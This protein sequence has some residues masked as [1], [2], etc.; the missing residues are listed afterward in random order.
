[1]RGHLGEGSEVAGRHGGAHPATTLLDT[2]ERYPELSAEIA[3]AASEFRM[4]D[5]SLSHSGTGALTTPAASW[6]GT[7]ALR[8]ARASGMNSSPSTSSRMIPSAPSGC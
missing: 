4:L 7:A 2:Y 3:A 5:S 8:G 6:A 1:M